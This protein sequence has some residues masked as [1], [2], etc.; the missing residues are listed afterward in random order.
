[1]PCTS[2]VGVSIKYCAVICD[3]CALSYIGSLIADIPGLF[4]GGV[5]ANVI[6]A[7]IA[8]QWFQRGLRK[9]RNEEV[10]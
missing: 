9:Q 7:G 1:M 10:A 6:T 5:V 4:V 2:H 8:W 3:V